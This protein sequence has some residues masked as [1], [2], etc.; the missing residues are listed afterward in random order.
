[1][2]AR[3]KTTTKKP[4]PGRKKPATV[5]HGKAKARTGSKNKP[6]KNKAAASKTIKVAVR[7]S[8]VNK[9]QR[10]EKPAVSE[11][12]GRGQSGVK[13]PPNKNLGRKV[14]TLTG[15]WIGQQGVIVRQDPVLGTYFIK[16]DSCQRDPVYKSLEWGPYFES[17][18]DF[19]KP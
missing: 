15:R 17:Q 18:L 3:K 14:K 4:A 11:A 8:P 2:A 12:S 10:T 13:K 6:I 16:F 9:K 19:L 1:M 7:K 5:K